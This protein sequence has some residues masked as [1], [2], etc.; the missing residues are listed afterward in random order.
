MRVMMPGR[1]VTP[2]RH[3]PD[4]SSFAKVPP[5]DCNLSSR[6]THAA[7][8]LSSPALPRG[9]SRTLLLCSSA[10]FHSGLRRNRPYLHQ[11]PALAGAATG[12]HAAATDGVAP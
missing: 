4:I 1:L 10:A 5:V 6:A 7:P 11:L 3:C 12:A 9:Q 8:A 2:V